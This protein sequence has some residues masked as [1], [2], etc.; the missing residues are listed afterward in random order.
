M[1]NVMSALLLNSYFGIIIC[2]VATP[3]CSGKRVGLYSHMHSCISMRGACCAS[4]SNGEGIVKKAED[5]VSYC[6]YCFTGRPEALEDANGYTSEKKNFS[7]I[8]RNFSPYRHGGRC[9]KRNNY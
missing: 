4:K 3:S 7:D 1:C 9:L 6:G 8:N 5:I 2:T